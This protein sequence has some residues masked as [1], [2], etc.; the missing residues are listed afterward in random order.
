MYHTQGFQQSIYRTVHREQGEEQH[1]ECTCHDQIRKIDHN[2]KKCLSFDPESYIRKP[3][4]QNQR[5]NNLWNES[6][7]PHDDRITDVFR[8]IC[9]QKFLIIFKS[10]KIRSYYGKS[11]SVIFE[12]TIIECRYQW[13]QL[14]H[15]KHKE[16]RQDEE[17]SPFCVT[18]FLFRAVAFMC[19]L[20][21]CRI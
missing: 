9:G 11:V 6:D 12:K 21:S 20:L 8:Q 18:Y 3:C 4:C 16:K 13:Y 19:I 1:C 15:K 7:Q 10:Y 17:V 5:Y 2:F 14:E